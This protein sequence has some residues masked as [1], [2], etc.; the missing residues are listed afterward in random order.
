MRTS[1]LEAFSDGVLAIIITIMVLEVKVPHGEEFA[2]LAD[3]ATATDS[4]RAM[5]FLAMASA[6]SS[7][8]DMGAPSCVVGG[9]PTLWAFWHK[10]GTG[11]PEARGA[12]AAERVEVVEIVA[13]TGVRDHDLLRVDAVTGQ[14]S[15]GPGSADTR[16]ARASFA[17][18]AHRSPPGAQVRLRKLPSGSRESRSSQPSV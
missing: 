4:L 8:C 7:S 16:S 12:A 3:S 1:R 13:V 6:R 14:R 5:S 9:S 10:R 15:G 2:D 18:G 11:N 17:G